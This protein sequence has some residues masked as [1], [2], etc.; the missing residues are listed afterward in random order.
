MPAL[1]EMSTG[2]PKAASVS[3]LVEDG[4]SGLRWWSEELSLVVIEQML[5]DK[6]QGKDVTAA[7]RKAHLFVG[8]DMETASSSSAFQEEVT[9]FHCV[10]K[11]TPALP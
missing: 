8:M 3:T 2:L 11:L 9:V 4:V 6:L 1:L 5:H 10:K 7:R